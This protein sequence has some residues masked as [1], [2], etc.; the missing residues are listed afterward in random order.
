MNMP[1][2][3]P[4]D[5]KSPLHWILCS[6]NWEDLVIIAVLELSTTLLE[7]NYSDVSTQDIKRSSFDG[8]HSQCRKLRKKPKRVRKD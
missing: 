4:S 8:P 7:R 6:E 2:D 5:E 3:P 1:Q